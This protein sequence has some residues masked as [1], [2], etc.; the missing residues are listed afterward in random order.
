MTPAQF[1]AAKQ[2]F[3]ELS[4][5]RAGERQ[6]KLLTL[7]AG[8]PA[9]IAEVE[10]LLAAHD[11]LPAPSELPSGASAK[12]QAA[13][14]YP[15]GTLIGDRYRIVA[16]LGHGGMGEVYRAE[17]IVLGEPVALKFLR[18]G[19]AA[20]KEM[21]LNELKLARQIAHPNVCRLFDVGELDGRF[22]LSMELIDGE[23]LSSLLQRIGRLPQDRLLVLARQLFSGLAAAHAK[24]VVHCDVKPANIMIDGRGNARLTD[25]G[26]ARLEESA[27]IGGLGAAGT[28]AYM[29]PE[30]FL[31]QRA[32]VRGD[33]YSLGLVLYEMCTGV[34][35]F[36]NYSRP[37]M[38]EAQL[39]K[40][41]PPPS[42]LIEIDPTLERLIQQ[43][44]EK[45][46]QDRPVS[47]L[48]VAAALSNS[49]PL[50][51]AL[52][53]GDTPPPELLAQ[54][55]SADALSAGQAAAWSLLVALT[56][57]LVIATS[58][59]AHRWSSV[60]I[61]LAPE[62]MAEKAREILRGFGW[63]EPPAAEAF[64]YLQNPG[65]PIEPDAAPAPAMAPLLFWYRQS[66][67][68][69]VPS[70]IGRLLFE[71]VRVG[72]YDPPTAANPGDTLL[73]LHPAGMLDHL[74]RRPH[75]LPG[76]TLR[77]G[78]A[79][80]FSPLLRSA[81]LDPAAFVRNPDAVIVP[82]F[83]IDEGAVAQGASAERPDL[84]ITVRMAAFQ[85]RPVYFRMQAQL[86][87]VEAPAGRFFGLFEDFYDWY[88]LIYIFGAL[89]AIPL[90][91]SNVRRG[92]GD[93]RGAWRLATFVFAIKMAI[94]LFDGF[95]VLDLRTQWAMVNLQV[96]QALLEAGL[97]WVFYLA[98]E[99]YVRKIW[100]QTLIT[101][102]RLLGGHHE[103][104]LL[105]RHLLVGICFG[106]TWML[107][108]QLDQLL[109]GLLGLAHRPDP[110]DV[111]PLNNA[112]STGIAL[113][114]VTAQALAAIYNSVFS[115]L[116][117]VLLR[118]LLRSAWPA[119]ALYVAAGALLYA[120]E[121]SHPWL[122][123]LLV[124][125]VLA[126]SEAW[127][128]VR[129][130]L[131]SL[132]VATLTFGLLGSFPITL[133]RQLWYASSGYAVIV[134]VI[135]LT[136]VALRRASYSPPRRALHPASE[137]SH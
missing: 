18:E 96:G 17:D 36:G 83:Y 3:L 41:P 93:R 63:T 47:A 54:A 69:M 104:R 67:Q 43:C 71:G 87:E 136:V 26:I 97:A 70:D 37:R 8:D 120:H 75:R 124:G 80:D 1:A 28:P 105:A 53:I 35:P 102:A 44:L 78:V 116:I 45:D 30:R 4:A 100:P 92:R 81:G 20:S 121:G 55:R 73:L 59:A 108:V 126:A 88:D 135:A 137:L 49:D 34:H 122:S 57:L 13:K 68:S 115:L 77:R 95:F 133:E 19:S 112:L 132:A 2:A 5:L 58:D 24:G 11:A 40:T 12:V 61:G 98:L 113:A 10:S 123:L 22:F 107:V 82:P 111:T 33:L 127:L 130:G 79:T 27:D 46:P 62:V 25:F 89:G 90:A 72:P 15:P 14:A 9:V 52:A 51:M 21:L 91:R 103:D 74:E 7:C 65:V 128:L 118:F 39:K 101:W 76:E 131:V 64:G 23:D 129:Y 119:I 94:F 56:L 60:E 114:T 31:G 86:P 106:A 125:F 110:V 117:L 85:G 32:T 48:M 109:P 42:S 50:E 99:P 84:P 66:Q 134:L 29:A 38:I 16:K 6:A